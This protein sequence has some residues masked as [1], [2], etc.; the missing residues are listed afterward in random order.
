MVEVMWESLWQ[1]SGSMLWS[2]GWEEVRQERTLS[3]H[4]KTVLEATVDKMGSA[5]VKHVKTSAH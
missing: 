3:L 4:L 5:Y 2:S 1:T